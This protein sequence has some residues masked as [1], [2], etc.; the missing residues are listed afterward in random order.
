MD[1]IIK[2]PKDDESDFKICYKYPFVASE[3]LAC[4]ILGLIKA[5]FEDA[6]DADSHMSL[7]RNFD[8]VSQES[9]N[10]EVV[11]KE[12]DEA[13]VK[14]SKSIDL[15]KEAVELK[16]EMGTWRLIKGD[17]WFFYLEKMNIKD[18]KYEMVGVDLLDYLLSFLDNKEKYLN[19]TLAGY[20]QKAINAIL[21]KRGFD[22]SFILVF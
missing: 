17:E 9:G 12:E 16:E 10:K 21:N 22:V 18:E 1:Y 13:G 20:F 8:Q 11:E 4:E 5:F 14:R 2:E 19:Q 7:S 15:K 3:I 6:A